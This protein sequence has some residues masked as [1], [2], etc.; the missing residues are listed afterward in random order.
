M[1]ETSSIELAEHTALWA[2]GDALQ[3]KIMLGIGITLIAAVIFILLGNNPLLKGTLIPLALV[4]IITVGYGGFIAFTRVPHAEKVAT[5]YE[6]DPIATVEQEWTK[7]NKD[8]MAYSRLKKI[9]PVLIAM[10]GIMFLLVGTDYLRGLSLGLTVAFLSGLIIDSLLDQRLQ[11]Y[12]N[13][14]T[15]LKQSLT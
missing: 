13:V 14:L 10:C 4:I 11:P 2:S 7:A 1:I 6:K 3:G 9:W 12:L 8:H 5:S 15:E